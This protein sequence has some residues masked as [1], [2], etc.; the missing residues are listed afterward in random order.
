[1][2]YLKELKARKAKFGFDFGGLNLRNV[3]AM[4]RFYEALQTEFESDKYLAE[5]TGFG[6][7]PDVKIYTDHE[8][9][10][11]WIRKYNP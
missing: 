3:V 8:E 4:G 1:M 2:I 9:V 11:E 7:N 10:A 6:S 5:M